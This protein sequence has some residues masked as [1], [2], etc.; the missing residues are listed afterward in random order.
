MGSKQ[1]KGNNYTPNNNDIEILENNIK[2]FCDNNQ[3][4]IRSIFDCGFNAEENI[5]FGFLD[6]GEIESDEKNSPF[7]LLKDYVISFKIPGKMN[8][9]KCSLTFFNLGAFL[10]AN[11][12]LYSICL[13][14]SYFFKIKINNESNEDIQKKINDCLEAI[15]K[16]DKNILNNIW[17][18][19]LNDEDLKS[20]R[21]GK[22]FLINTVCISE[23]ELKK[24]LQNSINNRFWSC[25]KGFKYNCK[26]L[27]YWLYIVIATI[28][29]RKKYKN[30]K[31]SYLNF[32]KDLNRKLIFERIISNLYDALFFENNNLFIIAIDCNQLPE[33]NCFATFMGYYCPGLGKNHFAR[34]L[35]YDIEDGFYEDSIK[36]YN[37]YWEIIYDIR[38]FFEQ[39]EGKINT[40]N[41]NININIDLDI[42]KLKNKDN[43]NGIVH[44]K[45]GI[46][47]NGNQIYSSHENS[48]LTDESDAHKR[49]LEE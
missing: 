16:K 3:H 30:D 9:T 26:N 39:N 43:N 45:R 8:P 27:G 14:Y 22:D 48:I 37:Y 38:K 17:N 15:D 29:S 32:K 44:K 36:V 4:K 42:K 11:G 40:I 21:V 23:E 5:R 18:S 25:W 33:D 13:F 35:K 1:F 19:N 10:G 28:F 20:L 24:E 6:N 47:E 46:V 12:F 34:K 2:N 31:T 49:L 7:A 41:K